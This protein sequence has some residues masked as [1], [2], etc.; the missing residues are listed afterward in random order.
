MLPPDGKLMQARLLCEKDLQNEIDNLPPVPH[1]RAE[2]EP[3]SIK[4][5]QAVA[6]EADQKLLL[7]AHAIKRTKDAGARGHLGTWPC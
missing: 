5:A 7:K 1:T 2:L 3:L 6:K 4:L